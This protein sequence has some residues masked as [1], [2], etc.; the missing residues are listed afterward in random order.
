MHHNLDPQATYVVIGA[1][2]NPEKYGYKVFKDLLDNGFQ[3]IPINPKGGKLL[4]QLVYKTIMDYPQEIDTAVFVVP[5]M[6]SRKVMPKIIE[7]GVTTVWFQ[8]GS[9]DEQAIKLAQ[10][11]SLIHI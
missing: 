8:P 9:Q 4:G 11:L 6:V 1:S 3:V 2:A 5:P 7:K 10:D